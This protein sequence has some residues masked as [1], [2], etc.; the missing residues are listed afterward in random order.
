M[1]AFHQAGSS[2]YSSHTLI[3]P[4]QAFDMENLF[5]LIV[6]SIGSLTHCVN[7]NFSLYP[8]PRIAALASSRSS[9]WFVSPPTI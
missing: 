4:V 8:L 7:H 3:I 6:V 1:A 9:K 5:L 2:L